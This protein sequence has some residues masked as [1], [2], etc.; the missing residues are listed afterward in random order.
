MKWRKSPHRN[1][2]VINQRFP[3]MRAEVV[4]WLLLNFSECITTLSPTSLLGNIC[5]PVIQPIQFFWT[6]CMFSVEPVV[7]DKLCQQKY[8][9]ATHWN[10]GFWISNRSDMGNYFPFPNPLSPKAHF[11]NPL[12]QEPVSH[13]E[14]P[15]PLKSKEVPSFSGSSF[16]NKKC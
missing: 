9:W 10:A 12:P 14:K 8:L 7:V 6:P 15:P 4:G 11:P 3:R 16:K 5:N 1:S 2:T 13:S